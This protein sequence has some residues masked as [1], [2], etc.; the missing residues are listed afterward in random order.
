[1]ANNPK[2]LA[3]S[4]ILQDARGFKGIVTP[5]NKNAFLNKYNL[6]ALYD[7]DGG[8]LVDLED[9]STTPVR[10]GRGGV[11]EDFLLDQIE[12]LGKWKRGK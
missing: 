5:T 12:R 1:M 4:I 3:K 8:D 10:V 6:G 2:E 7:F 9:M 11:Q